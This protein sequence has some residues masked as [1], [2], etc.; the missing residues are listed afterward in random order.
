MNYEAMPLVRIQVENMKHSILN[1]MGV[2][3]SE[4][5]E[6]L[7]EQIQKALNDYP[8]EQ[9]V[10]RIVREEVTAQIQG[11]FKYGNGHRAISESIEEA[12]KNLGKE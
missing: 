9:E 1:H 12:F 6:A 10:K 11:F 8:W 2:I 3:G 4:Y 7:D 5:A